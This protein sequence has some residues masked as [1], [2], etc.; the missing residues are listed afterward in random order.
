VTFGDPDMT[1]KKAQKGRRS[2]FRARHNCDDAIQS[3]LARMT[4]KGQKA[5]Y[6]GARDGSNARQ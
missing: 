1:I 5:V 6:F 4:I 2:N 3:G